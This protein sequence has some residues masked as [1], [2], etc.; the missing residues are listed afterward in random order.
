MYAAMVRQ[1][2]VPIAGAEI[3]PMG[4]ARL[5]VEVV[6]AALEAFNSA[7]D[8]GETSRLAQPSDGACGY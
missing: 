3:R 4:R 5:T 7:V 2:G 8:A 1:L 6:T